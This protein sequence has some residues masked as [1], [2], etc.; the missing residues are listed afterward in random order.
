MSKGSLRWIDE[1]EPFTE[2][3]FRYLLSHRPST[4]I[5]RKKMEYTQTN[6]PLSKLGNPNAQVDGVLEVIEMPRGHCVGEVH[7]R[8]TEFTCRCPVTNQP[9]WAIIDIY[10]EP[11]EKIVESKSVKM[12][13][14]TWR[15]KGI[16]HE[17]LAQS[18][19]EDFWK[20]LEPRWINVTVRFNTRGGIAITA[21]A[22]CRKE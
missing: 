4:K 11:D 15:D 17:V 3:Q 1:L 20:V 10:Y 7:L 5:R 22:S 13:L 18:I 21:C 9:D 14:E 16:F 12:Y 2:R 19:L 6:Q 8:C